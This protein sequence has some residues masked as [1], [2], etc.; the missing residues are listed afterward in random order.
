MYNVRRFSILRYIPGRQLKGL[1]FPEYSVFHQIRWRGQAPCN[2]RITGCVCYNRELEMVTGR[3]EWNG[4]CNIFVTWSGKAGRRVI[5]HGRDMS[6]VGRDMSGVGRDIS[7]VGRDISGV[8]RD[9]SGVGRD[10]SGVGRDMSGVGRDMSGVGRD[11]SG[12]GRDMSGVGRD[13]L[14]SCCGVVLHRVN[15]ETV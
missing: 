4:P 9:M 12:V 8:G 15:T 11:M 13:M 7:G 6:G 10:M 2:M 1:E 5:S 14:K 3:V